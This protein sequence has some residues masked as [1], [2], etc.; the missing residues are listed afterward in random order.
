MTDDYVPERGYRATDKVVVR[1]WPYGWEQSSKIDDGHPHDWELVYV[2]PS[3]HMDVEPVVRCA[4]CLAPRCGDSDERDPCMSRR[5]HRD[6]HIT[7]QGRFY[8]VGSAR[9]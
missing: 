8:P 7:L 9:F 2:R 4:V 5:H 1:P 6:L 3:E